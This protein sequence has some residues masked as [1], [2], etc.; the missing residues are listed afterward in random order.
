M[1]KYAVIAVL[2]L[3]SA[4]N[5]SAQGFF[6][7][8]QQQLQQ[9]MQPGK[10]AGAKEDDGG[11]SSVC[12]G[13]LGTPFKEKTLAVSP[14]QLVGKYFRVSTD[15]DRL[16]MDG[17]NQQYTGS[18]VS[19]RAHLDDFKDKEAK[20]LAEAFVANPS[21]PMLAQVIQYAEAG[22]GFTPQ[23]GP[24][25]LAEAQALLAMTMMQY[26]KLTLNNGY[27][28][29]FLKYSESGES[30]LGRALLARTYLFGDY[31]QQN[32]SAFSNYIAQASKFYQVKLSDQSIIYALQHV[33]NWQYR[34]QYLDLQRSSQ[35][36]AQS[37]TRQQNAA[38]SSDTNK[39]AL[40]LMREGETI[41]GLTLEALGAGPRM[42]ELRAKAEM[43]RKEG[44][45]EAN[46]IEIQAN[47]SEDYSNEIKKLMAASPQLDAA[48]KVKLTTA[49]KL[50]V[51]NLGK[52]YGLTIEVALKF[53]S[54][55]IGETVNSGG[56]INKYFRNACS[57][58]SRQ[59]ELGKQ[60]GIPA[61]V[62]KAEYL[63]AGM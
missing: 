7:K 44:A 3:A 56:M 51:D 54:G 13:A 50:K 19:I 55:D 26:P 20:N 33:P 18:M 12:R 15:M 63:A 40:L 35:D 16:L 43:L 32:I 49:N 62:V 17:I 10:G 9:A 25:E 24:S 30:G 28:N 2:A 29:Q 14:E 42:A 34:Q 5:A 21:V 47:Q 23:R 31:S 61:P 53:F 22:D 60:T 1:N 6:L 41:D 45:G 59:L 48:A 11:F 8:M 27:V 57:V 37:I 52:M 39:R 38:K 36:F 58:G 46:L 4:Q